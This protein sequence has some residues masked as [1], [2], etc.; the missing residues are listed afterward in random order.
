MP[1]GFHHHRRLRGFTLI[2]IL[3][4]LSISVGLVMLMAILYRSTGQTMHSLRGIGKEWNLQHQL[5]QQ[6]D[7]L[8]LDTN[9]GLVG[10]QGRQ[11]TLYLTTWYSR[12]AGMAG[13]PV[14]ALYRYNAARHSID[15]AEWP[16]PPWWDAASALHSGLLPDLAQLAN[17]LAPTGSEGDTSTLVSGIVA[18]HLRYHPAQLNNPDT[19]TWE[20]RW[21]PAQAEL[22]TLVSIEIER[23]DAPFNLIA[24][25][26]SVAGG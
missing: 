5:R 6:L 24:E 14:L 25:T 16:L 11:D 17:R 2:E 4:V 1:A 18:F 19:R 9:M 26:R 8:M 3:I 10:L 12:Q 20:D 7:H 13:K 21:Q 15:Y 23:N 22:P